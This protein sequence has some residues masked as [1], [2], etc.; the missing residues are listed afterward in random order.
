MAWPVPAGVD[1]MQSDQPVDTSSLEYCLSGRE[2]ESELR[3]LTAEMPLP[4]RISL[5][6]E[7]EPDFFYSLELEGDLIDVATARQGSRV[8]GFATQTIRDR[9]VNGN[10]EPVA[11]LGMARI[12]PGFRGRRISPQAFRM[13]RELQ[14]R[15][16]ITRIFASVVATRSGRHAFPDRPRDGIPGF[17]PLA[18]ICTLV[19]PVASS[20]V[21]RLPAQIGQAGP[22]DLEAIVLCLNRNN[23]RYQYSEHWSE[24]DFQC[25]W[26]TRGLNTDD[27]VIARRG[28]QV[29][30][31]AALWD[32]RGFKQLRIHSYQTA[33]GLAKPIINRM[34][35]ILGKP[36]LPAPGMFFEHAFA[37]H[38]A[39]DRDEPGLTES[40][41]KGVMWLASQRGG[42][43]NVAIGLPVADPRLPMIRKVLGGMRYDTTL[44]SV[45]WPEMISGYEPP[46]GVF[47]PEIA[48]L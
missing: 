13:F 18:D 44:C 33:V 16:D 6:Y 47:R 37:S 41:L 7:R 2:I 23:R 36:R 11:Y 10:P 4:G 22:E 26:L 8:V 30:G 27:F 24:S 35:G 17:Q 32:Q 48:V 5:S 46:R 1:L 20:P 14:I 28:R 45:L 15:R 9:Y 43:P 42:I 21:S 12:S 31:C 29:V 40:L 34:S 25:G 39:V 3:R 19:V 38:I